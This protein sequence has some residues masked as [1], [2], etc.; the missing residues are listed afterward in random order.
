MPSNS[1]RNQ[2]ARVQGGLE[3]HGND[4]GHKRLHPGT[5]N[6]SIPCA[7]RDAF[8]KKN[9]SFLT[10]HSGLEMTT[11]DLSLEA[12][13]AL[14]EPALEVKWK[15]FTIG[16]SAIFCSLVPESKASISHG[17]SARLRRS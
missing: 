1:Q 3:P 7:C 15:V 12:V 16:V 5:L 13:L 8:R 2:S 4:S 17:Q 14:E 9:R 11:L 6:K 10:C